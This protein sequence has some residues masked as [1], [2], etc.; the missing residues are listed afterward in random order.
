MTDAQAAVVLKV[1]EPF[2]LRSID[3]DH[4]T[5][6]ESLV[7]VRASGLC[8]SDEHIRKHGF[9]FEFPTVLGH[10]VAGEIVEVGPD[11]TQF[12]A[13]DRVAATVIKSCRECVPCLSGRPTLCE[14][15]NPTRRPAGSPARITLDGAPLHQFEAL[16]GFAEYALIHE[17]QLVPI[18]DA[19]SY[20]IAAIISCGVATGAGAA[21]NA[22][23]IRA[24]QIVAVIGCGGVGLNA[25]SG[26]Q[27]R[28]A[29]RIAAVD[30]HE[31]KLRLAERF[32]AT[33]FV[34]SSAVDPEEALLSLFPDGVDHAFEFVGLESTCELAIRVA[35][36]GGDVYI[37]GLQSPGALIG[38]R[39]W[40][41]LVV[42]QKNI[43]GVIM[44][45]TNFRRDI[46][47]YASLY[48]Q[49]R[50]NL[51]DLVGREITLPELSNAYSDVEA[52][53]IGRA[54]ITSF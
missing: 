2:S 53:S 23:D 54:V 36:R 26:A 8:H 22:A 47:T 35:R 49:G 38:V 4:P 25:I 6:R 33:D 42:G 30:I 13:G 19:L 46:Q 9:G 31:E 18:P 14:A 7:R 27:L 41:D 50:M 1:G 5:G 32:G 12:T 45:F 21:L 51:D 48:E 24:G 40:E 44:G 29:G 34:D 3:V 11:V 52:G 17:S 20:P 16:S 15:L 10:E 37:L 39:P 43:R 28:G